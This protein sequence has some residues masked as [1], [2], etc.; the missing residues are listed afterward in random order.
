M[1]EAG[2]VGAGARLGE[3]GNEGAIGAEGLEAIGAEKGPAILPGG[4][5]GGG[6]EP[7]GGG[8]GRMLDI[9][10]MPAAGVG[11]FCSNA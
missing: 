3:L 10:G 1:E 7:D 9:A 2:R 8:G 5:G 4:G 6:A 11:D